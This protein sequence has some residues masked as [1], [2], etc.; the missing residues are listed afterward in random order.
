MRPVARQVDVF[1]TA[2]KEE[3]KEENEE[4]KEEEEEEEEE[5]VEEEER[6]ER[7]EGS[8]LDSSG[9]LDGSF[10]LDGGSHQV[11]LSLTIDTLRRRILPN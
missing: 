11:A 1:R 5:K 4:M 3:V 2:F 7:G 8:L 9:S 10:E 6:E